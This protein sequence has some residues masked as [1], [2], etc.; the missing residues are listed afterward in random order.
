MLDKIEYIFPKN[1]K[2]IEFLDLLF[3]L[4]RDLQYVDINGDKEISIVSSNLKP[5]TV[6]RIDNTAH[7]L[8]FGIGNKD[9]LDFLNRSVKSFRKNEL[10]GIQKLD[11]KSVKNKLEGHV[12][13]I[14]HTG[15]NLP[16]SLY[17]KLEWTNLLRYI[18]SVSNLYRYPTNEPWP[19]L[20]PATLE[21]N[22]NEI[23][24]FGIV[25]E[26]RF[27]LVYDDYTDATTIQLDI[28]TDL[29]KSEVEA[30]FPKNQGIYFDSLKDI[31]KTIYIDYS[32]FIDI[33]FDVRYTGP[34]SDF[35]S[36][37]WFVSKGK[38]ILL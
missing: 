29:S 37:E 9:Y 1:D 14:D 38:R 8:Q 25:R 24:D 17:S 28:E 20:L 3:C 22:Q 33:R 26:P 16:T 31:F 18:S 12:T 13:R 32:E 2:N 11:M 35:E 7:N 36:G 30:L 27:E 4:F 15:I 21:E 34:C 6:F 23:T 5:E 19:F 10:D